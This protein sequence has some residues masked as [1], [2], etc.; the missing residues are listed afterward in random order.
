MAPLGLVEF[1]LLL[2][3]PRAGVTLVA[4]RALDRSRDRVEPN[5]RARRPGAYPVDPLQ[6][7]R[8]E[9]EPCGDVD[10]ALL[11]LAGER[12]VL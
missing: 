3:H 7:A 4:L 10:V 9:L 5:P 2:R 11:E 1:G 6:H 12:E 8:H